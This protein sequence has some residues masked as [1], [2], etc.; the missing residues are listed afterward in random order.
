MLKTDSKAQKR[1]QFNT[2]EAS[3]KL[4]KLAAHPVDLTKKGVLTHDRI[5]Y[6]LS[7]SCGLKVLYGTQ[8]IDEEVMENLK[9]LAE[10]AQ[11]IHKMEQMQSGAIMNK[12][13]GYPS[14]NR[15]VLHTAMRDLFESTKRTGVAAE[16]ARLAKEE[17]AKL[18]RFL[19]KIDEENH[20]TNMVVVAIGGSDLGPR[21]VFL[22]LKKYQKPHRN[23]HFFSNVDPDDS[24]EVLEGLD[25]AKTLV[26]VVSKSGTTLE[27]NTNEELVRDRFKKAKLDP[28]KHFVAVSSKGSPMD[29]PSRYLECFHMWDYVGGRFSTTS[30]CGAVSI[31]FGLGHEVFLEFLKGAHE[32]DQA[33]LNPDIK[34][35]PAL[36]LALLGIWNR[37]F[38]N[39]SDCL[40]IPYSQALFRFPAH[41]QQVD[42]ESNGKHIDKWGNR[43][44]FE[45]GPLI[46]GEPGTNAQHSFYQ[47]VHQGTDIVALELIGFKKTQR[48]EDFT[49]EG[50]TSHE[51]LLSNLF[52]QALA[53]AE[54][55]KNVNPN[56]GF[57]GNRPSSVILGEQLTPKT[58]GSL[59]ALYEHKVAFQGFIWDINSF[60]QEGVQLGKTLALEFIDLFA[61]R[62]KE[63]FPIGDAYLEILKGC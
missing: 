1:S 43:V 38:L 9:K 48:D 47:L 45:T 6:Y 29:D 42:M 17:H 40:C 10:E 33:A 24:A 8:R 26:V 41:V 20:F 60:D 52:A 21:S 63:P 59:F 51:K 54:G 12:I 46:W 23:V 39:Y 14:E 18:E 34:K 4:K 25:L 50:T 49:Y 30:M 22:S 7:E 15:P 44:D 16:A 56:K 3:Q 27:T 61:K 55:Q 58:M 13:E 37:N 2:Y 36:L 11:A 57:E 62:N 35:N 19:K 5:K 53:L 31:S 28:N 32:M